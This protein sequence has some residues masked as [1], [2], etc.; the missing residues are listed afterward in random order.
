MRFATGRSARDGSAVL[1]ATSAGLIAYVFAVTP[2]LRVVAWTASA[3][4]TWLALRELGDAK[5]QATRT[6]A[7]AWGAQALVVVGSWLA[8]SAVMAV[9]VGGG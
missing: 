7:I 2:E 8:R 4:I 1:G 9:L 3:A 6:V 5:Q